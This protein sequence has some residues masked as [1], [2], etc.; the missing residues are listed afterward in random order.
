[1]TNKFILFFLIFLFWN[2]PY[3]SNSEEFKLKS[4]LI[5]IE[6]NGDLVTASGEVEITTD[7]D[8]IINSDK[9][10][11]EKSKSF[12]KASGNVE[13]FDKI[14]DI[15]MYAN[16]VEYNKNKEIIFIPGNS[17]TIFSKNYILETANL[18]YDRNNMIILS[19]LKME[20]E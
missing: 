6:N 17:K 7:K 14:N 12:L 2:F 15:E 19:T 13:I 10:I 11:L 9:S 18:Y 8:L 16:Q 4:N 3:N 1:M 20:K 5:N